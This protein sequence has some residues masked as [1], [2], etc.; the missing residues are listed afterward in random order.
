[1]FSDI[2]KWTCV[3]LL[4]AGLLSACGGGGSAGDGEQANGQASSDPT[5]MVTPAAS[6]DAGV[7]LTY[8]SRLL[9]VPDA[10]TDVLEPVKVP[11][12]LAEDDVSEPL[13]VIR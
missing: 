2:L 11:E 1:M 9:A 6:T 7:L 10:A 5:E 3:G 4:C 12:H 13:V 8:T